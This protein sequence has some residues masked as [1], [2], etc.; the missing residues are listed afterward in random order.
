MEPYPKE[1]E[2]QQ[3]KVELLECIHNLMG[4]FDTPV[5]RLKLKNSFTEEI[6]AQAKKIL[7]K[8]NIHCLGR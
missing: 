6:R 5:A 1:E 8:N 4:V 2:I 3:S 7:E